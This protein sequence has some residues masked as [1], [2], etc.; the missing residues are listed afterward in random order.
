M[1]VKSANVTARVEPEV[2]EKA[3]AIL[4]EMG[5][6]ASTEINI[7]YRQIVLWNG[8]PFRPSTPP[9]RPRSREEMPDEEFDARMAAGL[10]QAKENLSAP[11]DE[12]FSRL[13]GEIAHGKAI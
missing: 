1:A 7:F 12:T 2:K 3:E 9:T 6:P 8:L 10:A 13:I 4:N 5:I 11:M